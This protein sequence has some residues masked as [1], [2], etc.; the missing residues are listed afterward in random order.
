MPKE[1]LN[2]PELPNWG[3]SFSQVVITR[4][5][6][7]RTIHVSGQVSADARN[8]VIGRGDLARQAD[9]AFENLAHALRAAGATPADVVRLEIY[10]VGYQPDQA[11]V[12]Q[13]ASRK[14]FAAGE[15][16]ASTWLGV[17]SLALEGLL[18][19]IE[20]TAIVE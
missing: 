7:T 11:S 4:T 3:E 12:I 20:A 10:V 14:V 13:R 6:S 2:P 18:I 1:R 16:P 9:Q 15:L 5:G 19:E 17:A 8:Q